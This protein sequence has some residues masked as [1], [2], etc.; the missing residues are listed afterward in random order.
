MANSRPWP[1]S[2]RAILKESSFQYLVLLK[3]HVEAI[4]RLKGPLAP[5]QVYIAKPYPFLAGS[6]KPDTYSKGNVWVFLELVAQ[7]HGL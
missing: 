4:H 7:M 2:S 3:P 1:T 5:G 6:E